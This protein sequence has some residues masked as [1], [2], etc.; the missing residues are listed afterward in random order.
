MS[1]VSVFL[2]GTLFL[3][4]LL[5]GIWSDWSMECREEEWE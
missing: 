5:T 1:I 3:T 4:G 2:I